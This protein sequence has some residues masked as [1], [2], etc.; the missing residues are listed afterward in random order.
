MNLSLRHPLERRDVDARAEDV[1]VHRLFDVGFGRAC[2][3]IQLRVERE[4]VEQV[5][6]PSDARVKAALEWLQKHYTLTE[7]PGMEKAG[8]YYYL[9][10]MAKGL[11][12]AGLSEIE[13]AD[14]PGIRG[15]RFAP[16]SHY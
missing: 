14:F 11:A 1:A 15:P 7:N 3:K 5:V 16:I 8:Y 12:A 13:V 6:K 4:Q 10:L 2:R 9:H